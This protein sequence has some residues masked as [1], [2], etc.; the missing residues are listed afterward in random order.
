M[1]FYNCDLIL[2]VDAKLWRKP[3]D[4]VWV[5]G[6]RGPET[7]KPARKQAKCLKNMVG[8]GGLEPPTKG[9]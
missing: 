8:P 9:L 4:S 2:K 5:S 7:T 1:E 3:S 6:I